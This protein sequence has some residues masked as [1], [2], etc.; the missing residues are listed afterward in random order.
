MPDN[1]VEKI[2]FGGGCH[3]CTEAV[4]QL[5]KGVEKVEQG[6]IASVG[7]ASN[8]SEAVIVHFDSEMIPLQRLILIHLKTHSSTSA[9]SMRDKYRSAIYAFSTEQENLA[10]K[11]LSQFQKTFSRKLITKVYPFSEFRPSG[12]EFKNY[13]LQDKEKPFCQRFIEPKRQF[14]FREFSGDIKED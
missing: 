1:R 5:L 12:A 9:H 4:F 3:W 8:F 13:Y 6:F 14:L 7:Q 11:I 2:G 10:N